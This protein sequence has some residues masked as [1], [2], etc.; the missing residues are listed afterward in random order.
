MK[1]IKI[2]EIALS[3]NQNED[4]KNTGIRDFSSLISSLEGA[5]SRQKS[6]VSSLEIKV[7]HSSPASSYGL[8]E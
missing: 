8:N 7:W 2:Y 6:L 4:Y 1:V 5:K 3:T